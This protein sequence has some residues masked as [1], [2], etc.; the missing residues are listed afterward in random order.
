MA[1]WVALCDLSSSRASGV[2]GG[3]SSSLIYVH[4]MIHLFFSLVQFHHHSFIARQDTGTLG[5]INHN[6]KPRHS[7]D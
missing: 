2:V 1:P 7:F 3:L 6:W 4:S 5:N